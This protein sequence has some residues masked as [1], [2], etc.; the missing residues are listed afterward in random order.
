MFE[1]SYGDRK[2][3]MLA[4]P[5]A[6]YCSEACLK[7]KAF[8]NVHEGETARRLGLVHWEIMSLESLLFV[9]WGET[10]SDETEV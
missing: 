8:G 6:F 9:F 4:E 7:A 1:R 10:N 3:T 2:K 5:D